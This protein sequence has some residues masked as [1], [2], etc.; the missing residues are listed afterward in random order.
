MVERRSDPAP[1][2]AVRSRGRLAKSASSSYL[3][4]VNVVRYAVVGLG[5]ISQTAVLPAFARAEGS[6]LAALVSGSPDKLSALGATY[7]VARCVGYDGYDALLE[8]GDVDAVF[9]ALPNHLHEEFAVRAARRGVHVLCE[10]PLAPTAAACERMIEAARRAS[11]RLM[12]AYR[13]YFEP[14]N[15]EVIR[16]VTSGM[17]G[18]PRI[19]ESVFSYQV[20]PRDVRLDRASGGGSLLDIGIYC[21]NAVRRIFQSEPLEVLAMASPSASPR[22]HGLVT[23]GAGPAPSDPRFAEVDEMTSVLLRFPG[24]RLA[25]FTSSFGASPSAWLRVTGQTGAVTLDSAYFYRGERRLTVTRGSQTE[26][27]V[28]PPMDQF[29][30]QLAHFSTC[31]REG[32]EP[33]PDGGEGLADLRVL[34]AVAASARTGALVEV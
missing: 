28:Y 21:V 31:V 25:S 6:S 10:K 30:A 34:E 26:V 2:S 33:L 32:R 23:P 17:I 24:D 8:S 4:F 14:A 13:L 29:A 5:H 1:S 9:I 27:Q 3:A 7:G 20:K 15:L 22:A 11:V 12:T 18:D 19:F 16:V